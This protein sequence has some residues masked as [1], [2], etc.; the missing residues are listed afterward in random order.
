MKS[1]KS[2][3]DNGEKLILE[4]HWSSPLWRDTPQARGSRGAV[5]SRRS[6]IRIVELLRAAVPNLRGAVEIVRFG[7]G[8][9]MVCRRAG[10]DLR[11]QRDRRRGEDQ[12][13]NNG[14]EHCR[15]PL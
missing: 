10:V 7:L 6:P 2:G 3:A 13:D 12:C 5:V 11:G 9:V 4:N 14:L 1:K 15:A 8:R